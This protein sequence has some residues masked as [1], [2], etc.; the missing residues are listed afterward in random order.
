MGWA[1]QEFESPDPDEVETGPH[2]IYADSLTGMSRV[3]DRG[4]V[5]PVSGIEERRVEPRIRPC[6]TERSRRVH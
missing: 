3:S 1:R 2:P 4:R 5:R 6:R